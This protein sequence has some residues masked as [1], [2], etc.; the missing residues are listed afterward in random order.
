MSQ[1][2]P[3]NRADRNPL[4]SRKISMAEYE[5]VLQLIPDLGLE[6]GWIQELGASEN[7]LPDFEREGYPFITT[8]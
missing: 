5:E 8:K 4:L 2:L 1:Y 7:Y 3:Q 6:N